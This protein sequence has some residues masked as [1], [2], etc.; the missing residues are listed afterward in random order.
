ME[1]GE[2]DIKTTFKGTTVQ[3]TIKIL[4]TLIAENLVKYFK[5]ESQFDI[6]LIDGQGNPVS[7]KTITMNINGVFY[8]RTTNE[9][10]MARLNINL[11]PGKYVLIAFDPLTDLQL[12]FT[13]TVL[14]TLTGK[15]YT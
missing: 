2:Y 9:N 11:Q 1:P 15:T 10:G 6:Q 14:P 5:N 8:N 12:S 3:N 13:I 4:P 7:G